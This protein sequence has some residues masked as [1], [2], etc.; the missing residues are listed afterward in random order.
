MGIRL[1]ISVVGGLAV[2]GVLWAGCSSGGSGG[3]A[4]PVP[5]LAGVVFDYTDRPAQDV[6]VEVVGGP[7]GLTRRDGLVL[8]GPVPSGNRVLKVGDSVTTPTLFVPVTLGAAPN[9]LTR[10]VHLPLLESGI[11]ANLPAAVTTLTTVSGDELPGVQLSLTAGSSVN[12]PAGSASEVRVLGISPS[13][14][15]AALPGDLACRVAY[16]VEPQGVQFSPAAT[17]TVPRLDPAG[18]GPFDLYRVEPSTGT[19]QLAQSN[20]APVSSGSEFQIPI[21]VGTMYAVVPSTAPPS[22]TLTGRVVVGTQPVQGYRVSCWNRVS[23]PTDADGRFQILNVP[24][25]Y[26]A[27][28]VRAYPERPAVDFAPA[29]ESQTS[30]STALGDIVLTAATAPDGVAPRVTTTSPADGA[31]NVNQASQVVVTFSEAIDSNVAEP[32]RLVGLNGQV[33]SRLNFESAFRVRILPNQELDTLADYTIVVDSDVR[34]LSGN[35]IDDTQL[36]FSFRTR[37][38]APDPPPTDT[39]AFGLS[40][41]S[42]IAGDTLQVLGRNFTGGSQVSFGGAASLVTNESSE[43]IDVQVPSAVPAGDV[44]VSVSAGGQAVPTQSPLVLDVRASV[45]AVFSGASPDMPLVTLDRAQPPATIVVDGANMGGTSITVDGISIA[46][47]D[48]TVTVGGSAVATGRA[49]TLGAPAPDTLFTGPIVVR[50]ANGEPS[51]TYRFL[52]V[53]E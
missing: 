2:G 47:V 20:V 29:L 36:T 52:Q 9:F 24:A 41:L 39:L 44:T 31:T 17:L 5:N 23:D 32:V 40:P 27:F 25:N 10:P 53:R 12:L 50:G 26:S 14:L 35:G 4:P 13:R 48:S 33:P 37:S 6:P 46:A 11:G 7:A 28:L 15:P 45:A 16:L 3:G 18:A 22:A 1:L 34:D 30:T 51:A 42:A 8:L 19:W 49:I 21:N 43:Q 38:G